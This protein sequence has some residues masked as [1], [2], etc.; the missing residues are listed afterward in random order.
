M[1]APQEKPDKKS[2]SQ[3]A[4]AR[5][6]LIAGR[7]Q[8]LSDW[9]AYISALNQSGQTLQAVAFLNNALQRAP[10]NPL[11]WAILGE[12]LVIHSEGHVSPA[13]LYAFDMTHNI[14]PGHPAVHYY[15]AMAAIED[16][17]PDD[18][19]GILRKLT[20]NSTLNRLWKERTLRLIELAHA[21]REAQANEQL[22]SSIEGQVL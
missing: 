20:D 11:L 4:S 1:P 10:D 13:A 6:R 17:R 22:R 12:T 19:L 7:L 14:L 3:V 5:D 9:A 2:V 8:S 18:A 16:A 21:Q 15:R